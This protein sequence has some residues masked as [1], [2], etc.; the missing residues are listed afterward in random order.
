MAGKCDICGTSHR[1]VRPRAHWEDLG[2][3]PDLAP[4]VAELCPRCATPRLR[5]RV[6]TAEGAETAAG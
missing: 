1:N 2:L 5:E 3:T 4:W 6:G